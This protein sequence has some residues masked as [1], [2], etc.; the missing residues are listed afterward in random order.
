MSKPKFKVGDKVVILDG[1]SIKD[2]TGGWVPDMGTYVGRTATIECVN[3]FYGEVPFYLFKEF[4]YRWDERG[5]RPAKEDKI[6]IYRNGDTVVAKNC[7]TRAEAKAVCSKDDEF[8]FSVGAKLALDRLLTIKETKIK[9]GCMVKITNVG[10]SFSTYD[11]WHGLKGY[12]SHFVRGKHAKDGKEYKVLFVGK[13]GNSWYKC[14]DILLIQD[15][16]TTQVFIIGSEGV[17]VVE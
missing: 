12:E 16:D 9:A 14:E 8:D 13:H 15:P 7:N 10:E 4:G 2:Y 5:L 17:E 3:G 6:I 11:S 1:N